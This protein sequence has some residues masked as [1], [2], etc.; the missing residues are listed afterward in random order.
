[1]S[2]RKFA[3]ASVEFAN[4]LVSKSRTAKTASTDKLGGL[5][6]SR[7]PEMLYVAVRA[8]S[9]RVN[10]NFDAFPSSELEAA[11][12]TFMSRPVFVNHHNDDPS[13]T[14]G[15]V[16][17][18]RY[19]ESGNDKYIKL[20]IE[21]D[22]VNFPRLA[23]EIVSGNIDSVS[24][25]TDV[26]RT[27]CSYCYNVAET[28]LDFCS[29][30][31]NNKG[32][33]LERTSSTGKVESVLVYEECRDLN[34]FEISFV[35]DPADETAVAS[36]V[37]S[38]KGYKLGGRRVAFGEPV[39]PSEVDTLRDDSTC[40]KCGEEFDGKQ[41]ISCGYEDMIEGFDEPDLDINRDLE[42][43]RV[44]VPEQ[45]QK[46]VEEEPDQ[47]TP[48]G[49]REEAPEEERNRMSRRLLKD[50]VAEARRRLAADEQL[51]EGETT[52][53]DTHA[54]EAPVDTME[55]ER[56][57]EDVQDVE[58]LDEG[59]GPEIVTEPDARVNVESRRRRAA[60][61]RARRKTAGVPD[62]AVDENGQ[63]LQV[64]QK[65]YESDVEHP[66]DASEVSEDGLIRSAPGLGQGTVAPW[67]DLKDPMGDGSIGWPTTMRK[68]TNRKARRAKSRVALTAAARRLLASEEDV[69]EATPDD[70]VDV[71]A[72]VQTSDAEAEDS[73][74]DRSDYDNNASENLRHETDETSNLGWVAEGRAKKASVKMAMELAEAMVDSGAIDRNDRF[75]YFAKF[76]QQ[77]AYRVR[78]K[79]DL[80]K[81]V[82]TAQSKRARK[83]EASKQEV[84]RPVQ[85]ARVEKSARRSNPS[86]SAPAASP[87][88]T[89]VA[90]TQAD[91]SL[92]FT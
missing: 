55:T 50:R 11:Y 34:F 58:N 67:V 59:L 28:P 91:D 79:L 53:E 83:T 75:E 90:D 78:E 74:Y 30:V 21:V 38:P 71:E 61:A 84:A 5:E 23:R 20:V 10:Q 63:K 13:R 39:A 36:E 26:Q 72:P 43:A 35:F 57:D 31:Q 92:L 2:I 14:R 22:A 70:R 89:K 85:R 42:P 8:I 52:I 62:W 19:M 24:M 77:P 17:A 16:V 25:G 47:G 33:V 9:S 46:Q 64:G 88:R 3:V 51:G 12:G 37:L 66:E 15:K 68:A 49:I 54:Y 69:Q 60:R 40:P 32:Q 7:R 1:M 29:H 65:Y 80:L 81:R 48:G 27:I 4:P 56:A 18:S 87:R 82:R 6:F 45:E 73:Q 76:E 41:C 86:L 44:E